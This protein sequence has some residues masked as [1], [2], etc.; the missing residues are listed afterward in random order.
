[1]NKKHVSLHMKGECG[2]KK[3]VNSDRVLNEVVGKVVDSEIKLRH[4]K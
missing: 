4:T 3:G 1:M 2:E